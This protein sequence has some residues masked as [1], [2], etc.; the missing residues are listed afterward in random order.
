METNHE[1]PARTH[2]LDINDKFPSFVNCLRVRRTFLEGGGSEIDKKTD[3]FSLKMT[4]KENSDLEISI[5]STGIITISD[6]GIT[7]DLINP[8]DQS[9][10][11][12]NV[13]SIDGREKSPNITTSNNPQ[14]NNIQ[15]EYLIRNIVTI[16]QKAVDEEREATGNDIDKIQRDTSAKGDS[17]CE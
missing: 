6:H 10:D 12:V 16:C 13:L 9:A 14:L 1:E 7:F 2:L 11:R 5:N 4:Q 15:L 17:V 3:D 8:N